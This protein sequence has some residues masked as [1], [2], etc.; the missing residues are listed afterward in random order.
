[1]LPQAG[2]AKSNADFLAFMS[3]D[4]QKWQGS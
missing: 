1:M 4:Y 2:A 3:R